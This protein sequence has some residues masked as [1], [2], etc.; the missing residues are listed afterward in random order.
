MHQYLFFIGNFPIRAYGT[1]LAIAIISGACVA[2][3]LTKK[4]GRG[5]HVHIVDFSIY[6]GIAGLIGARLWDVLFFDWAYYHNH[7]LEIP[8]VWQGGMAIQGGVVLGTLVG[9]WYTKKHHIDTWAFADLFAPALILAQSIGRM[10]NLMNGDAFGTP[11][12][13]NFGIL[14]PE[15][16]LA[17]HTY[18]NQPLWPA[19]VWEGQIDILIFVILLLFSSFTH[20]KG[21][22][23]CLYAF[24]Y[25]LARFCLEFLRGDY[26]QPAFLTFTSAQTTSLIVMLLSMI[27]FTY[28][29]VAGT[30]HKNLTTIEN[31]NCSPSKK[32]KK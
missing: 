4:D 2:Y 18:G 8:F 7:L 13:S 29:Q 32:R 22:V 16:T 14:Y 31:K 15:T 6:V 19:E 28:L 20:K 30:N 24:L 3:Y 12:G 26:A 1:L 23:F 11:T 9:I 17:Y 10:A 27:V 5:W 25:S 21:Q